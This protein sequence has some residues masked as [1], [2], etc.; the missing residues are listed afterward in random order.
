[1]SYN[2]SHSSPHKIP[3]TDREKSNI[4]WDNVS[5][6]YAKFRPS[7]PISFFRILKGFDIGLSKQKILDLGTGTGHLALQFARQ[8]SIVSGIDNSEGQLEQAKKQANDENLCVKFIQTA[9]EELAFPENSFDRATAMQCWP[10][11][12]LHQVVE[13]LREVLKP[14]VGTVMIGNFDHLPMIDNIAHKTEQLM[15]KY[16]PSWKGAGY[17]GYIPA[18][19]EVAG[20]YFDIKGMFFFDEPI[21]FTHRSW[22]GRIIATQAIGASLNSESVSNFSNEMDIMLRKNADENFNVIHRLSAHILT[23]KDNI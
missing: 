14:R 13:K 8:E 1:M 4:H 3:F 20:S 17:D 9:V 7:P 10:Y 2:N 11:F 15:L 18:Y 5:Y 6:Y 12:N 19:P 22:L 23:L 21:P 16:N